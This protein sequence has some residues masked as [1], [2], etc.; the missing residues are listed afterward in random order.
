VSVVEAVIDDGDEMPGFVTKSDGDAYRACVVVG[1][2][3]GRCRGWLRL[4]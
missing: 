4:S 1:R 3:V 2:G